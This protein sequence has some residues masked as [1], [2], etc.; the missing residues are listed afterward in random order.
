MVKHMYEIEYEKT[1]LESRSIEFRRLQV[2]CESLDD[3]INI[4]LGYKDNPE[5]LIEI[6][7]YKKVF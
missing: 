3:A 2:P 5:Q 6:I 7:H 1:D 4:V